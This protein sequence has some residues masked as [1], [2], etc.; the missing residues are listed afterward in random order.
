MFNRIFNRQLLRNFRVMWLNRFPRVVV[1][2]RFAFA[3]RFCAPRSAFRAL[4]LIKGRWTPATHSS[5]SRLQARL[6][7]RVLGRYPIIRRNVLV[8]LVRGAHDLRLQSY[9]SPPDI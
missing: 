3:P 9:V 6:L 8:S 4:L 2:P 1:R 7:A 5:M